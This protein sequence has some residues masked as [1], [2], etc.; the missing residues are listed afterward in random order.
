MMEI[1]AVIRILAIIFWSIVLIGLLAVL[2]VNV[3]KTA[4]LN[5]DYPTISFNQF[6]ALYRINPEKWRL[7]TSYVQY[8]CSTYQ[9]IYHTDYKI[10]EFA[11][12]IDRFKY[13]K[14]FKKESK[15]KEDTRRSKE[16][17]SLITEWQ[18]DIDEA[19]KVNVQRTKELMKKNEEDAKKYGG[20]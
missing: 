17:V 10:I 3:Y 14:W 16:M 20:I 15:R 2:W 19:Q 18:K 4:N 13:K 6:I 11:T 12:I 8:S 7:E 1:L 9:I 5:S